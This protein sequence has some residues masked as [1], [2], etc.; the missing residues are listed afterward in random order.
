ML[1]RVLI[2]ALRGTRTYVEVPQ[3]N[4]TRKA[5]PEIIFYHN[6]V[7]RHAPLIAL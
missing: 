3:I 1:L 4:L 7:S 2:K 5:F 6:L